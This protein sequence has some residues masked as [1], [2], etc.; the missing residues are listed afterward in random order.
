MPERKC[1]LNVSPIT[2]LFRLGSRVTLAKDLGALISD[3]YPI[4]CQRVH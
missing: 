3:T 2:A 4:G 1:F